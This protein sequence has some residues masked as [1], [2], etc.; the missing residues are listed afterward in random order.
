MHLPDHG[1][2]RCWMMLSRPELFTEFAAGVTVVTPTRRLAHHLRTHHDASCQARALR[3]WRTADVVT[4]NELLHRQ[5]EAD[6]A[7]GR[8]SARWLPTTLA[9]HFWEQMVRRDP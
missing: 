5:F 3:V 9:R 8:T 1:V 6:R 4:W 2:E 7:A